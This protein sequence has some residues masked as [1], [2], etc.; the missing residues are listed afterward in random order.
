MEFDLKSILK[1][2]KEI[3]RFVLGELLF[4]G[5]VLLKNLLTFP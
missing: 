3:V 5:R 2:R 4:T 1:M